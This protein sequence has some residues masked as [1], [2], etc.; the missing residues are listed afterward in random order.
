MPLH[1]ARVRCCLQMR[2][3]ATPTH[4]HDWYIH[5]I[6][7]ITAMWSAERAEIATRLCHELN[8]PFEASPFA[9]GSVALCTVVPAVRGSRY[10]E[11]ALQELI[12]SGVL[13]EP[14]EANSSLIDKVQHPA[15]RA[16]CSHTPAR[17]S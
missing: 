5:A 3:I 9:R 16:S 14:P 12:I 4:E 1:G 7:V 10:T 15:V 17:S 13:A 8:Q 11:Q 2:R 6:R